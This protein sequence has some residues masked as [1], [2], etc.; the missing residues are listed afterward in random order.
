MRGVPDRPCAGSQLEVGCSAADIPDKYFRPQEQPRMAARGRR[1]RGPLKSARRSAQDE[2]RRKPT[3]IVSHHVRHSIRSSL[4]ASAFSPRRCTSNSECCNWRPWMVSRSSI[5]TRTCL[6][7]LQRRWTEDRG[8]QQYVS[9]RSHVSPSN[10]PSSEVLKS[11][12][13]S[14][15]WRM[16]GSSAACISSR[17]HL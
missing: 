1:T 4:M 17:A 5:A 14:P 8:Q 3:F 15:G 2:G 9:S 10:S 16:A 6:M 13:R 12:G 7:D 11:S